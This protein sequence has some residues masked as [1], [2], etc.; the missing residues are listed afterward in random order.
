MQKR[1]AKRQGTR[2]APL[3]HARQVRSLDT[4]QTTS[5]PTNGPWSHHQLQ[6]G[7]ACESKAG[8]RYVGNSYHVR[9]CWHELCQVNP[10]E[11]VL[12]PFLDLLCASCGKFVCWV[13]CRVARIW[14][15]T[16]AYLLRQ[17]CKSRALGAQRAK[18]QANLNA[19]CQNHLDSRLLLGRRTRMAPDSPAAAGGA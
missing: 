10:W 17:A 15:I 18:V 2:F 8:K 7:M 6:S 3:L 1:F 5:R 11:W 9:P 12:H 13:W 14:Q 16:Q 4:L 19:R